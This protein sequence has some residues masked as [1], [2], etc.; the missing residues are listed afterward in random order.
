MRYLLLLL[1]I[2]LSLT[3]YAHEDEGWPVTENCLGE[4]PYPTIPQ[5]DWDFEGVIFGDGGDAIRG[6]RTDM[7][8]S[9]IVA[10][11]DDENFTATGSFSP[12]GNWFAYTTGEKHPSGD[13]VGTTH[14]EV[15]G[16]TVV[17]GNPLQQRTEYELPEE[18]LSMARFVYGVPYPLYFNKILWLDNENLI[19]TENVNNIVSVQLNIT[20]GEM[21]V[22]PAPTGIFM[23]WLNPMLDSTKLTNG[24]YVATTY[25]DS[26]FILG[27]FDADGELIEEISRGIS[28]VSVSEE[29]ETLVFLKGNHIHVANLANHTIEDLCFESLYSAYARD[30]HYNLILSPDGTRLAFLYD[31]YP[32]LVNLETHEMQILRFRTLTLMGWYPLPE[33]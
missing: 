33:E 6:I 15:T 14:Y 7:E 31:G 12:D 9:Y 25:S 22:E 8:T 4:L 27:I 16:L 23:Q 11:E 13:L 30:V 32:V 20:T 3:S 29:N 18:Y 21:I 1:L 2:S 10:I 24:N 26:V 17:S 5:E 28:D 19:Y